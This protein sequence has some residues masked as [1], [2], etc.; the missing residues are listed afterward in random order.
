MVL[1]LSLGMA[2]GG[3]TK[4]EVFCFRFYA[5]GIT[6]LVWV[7]VVT[8]LQHYE[9]PLLTRAALGHQTLVGLKVIELEKKRL[10]LTTWYVWMNREET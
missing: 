8:R 5:E 3:L 1:S 4:Q 2:C 7:A 6:H 9:A 10:L